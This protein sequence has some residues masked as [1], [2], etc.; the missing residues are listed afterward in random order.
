MRYEGSVVGFTTQ[1]PNYWTK[2]NMRKFMENAARSRNLDP[3]RAETWYS[4]P[5]SYIYEITV[6]PFPL[7]SLS[8][9]S[10]SFPLS[11]HLSEWAN[12]NAKIEGLHK[13]VTIPVS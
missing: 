13:C 2:A 11:S 1:P 5:V 6:S 10:L 12:D 4:I 3:L 8:L 7:S 9:S